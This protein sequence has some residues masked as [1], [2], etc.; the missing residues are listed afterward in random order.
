MSAAECIESAAHWDALAVEALRMAE[1]NDAHI[2]SGAAQR[3]KAETYKRT[4]QALRAE[5][6]TGAPHCSCCLRPLGRPSGPGA[7]HTGARR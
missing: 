5:A 6:E 1:W 2:G 4:A 7:I 3:H